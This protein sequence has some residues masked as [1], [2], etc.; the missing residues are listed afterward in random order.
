MITA[1]RSLKEM[2]NMSWRVKEIKIR[3]EI[4]KELIVD[5]M[6]LKIFLRKFFSIKVRLYKN[7]M[8]FF[9]FKNCIFEEVKI[10]GFCDV[11]EKILYIIELNVD[12]KILKEVLK[13][14]F[15]FKGI[16]LNFLWGF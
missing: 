3:K 12:K 13:V 11:F 7:F 2:E 9:R 5:Y 4:I 8:S 16:L 6:F 15:F 10:N 14:V 1:S